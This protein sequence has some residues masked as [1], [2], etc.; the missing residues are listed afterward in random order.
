ML[1]GEAWK[2]APIY[3]KC[4][5]SPQWIHS[6]SS[7]LTERVFSII[8]GSEPI[9][10]AP[11]TMANPDTV[12]QSALTA[13]NI[14]E[15]CL[16]CLNGC[17][18][19]WQ[20]AAHLDAHLLCFCGCF[21]DWLDWLDSWLCKT[22]QST[23][24]SVPSSWSCENAKSFD[25]RSNTCLSNGDDESTYM[26][27]S[28]PDYLVGATAGPMCWCGITG[29]FSIPTS[30]ALTDNSYSLYGQRMWWQLSQA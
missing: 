10:S 27:F 22:N 29:Q 23:K 3:C 19:D 1:G 8:S 11:A 16:D 20:A 13:R 12:E 26:H 15:G 17:A 28:L 5:L 7:L 24:E 9:H 2:L 14:M 25:E 4:L 6:S 30:A 21:D 18:D